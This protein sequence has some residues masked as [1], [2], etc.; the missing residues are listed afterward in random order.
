MELEAA[1]LHAL[2]LENLRKNFPAEA[3]RKVVEQGE[4]TALKLGDS[5]DA[6][7]LL[8]V[9]E[10][11]RD[12][13]EVAALIPDQDSLVLAPVPGDGDWGRLREG[14]QM[15]LGHGHRLLDRPLRVS[16]TSIE[17]V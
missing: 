13:E 3:V 1:G 15:V 12:G 5:Y 14:E 7:R 17:P 4:G 10:H 2:A 6:A 16:R 9:P 8:L 11:L